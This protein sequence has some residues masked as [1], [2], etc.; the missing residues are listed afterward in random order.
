MD[1]QVNEIEGI[2]LVSLDGRFD[3]AGAQ[4]VDPKFGALAGSVE[5]LAVDLS[6]VTFLASMGIRTLM[7]TAKTILRRGGAMVVF[8][9]NVNVESVL[10]ATGFDEIVSI[11]PDLV[12]AEAALGA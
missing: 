8:G 6:R 5:K 11:H 2:T 7:L 9:P 1:M 12:A 3:I 4:E 10:R